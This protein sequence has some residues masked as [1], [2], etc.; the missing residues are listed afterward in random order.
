MHLLLDAVVELVRDDLV[1]MVLAP[2]HVHALAR[3]GVPRQELH[4]AQ[5][6][7][8]SEVWLDCEDLDML[9]RFQGNLY[10]WQHTSVVIRE[11]VITMLDQQI[12]PELAHA[13]IDNIELH[14]LLLAGCWAT[15]TVMRCLDAIP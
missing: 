2:N 6:M 11:H 15:K 13:V 10:Y 14:G 12:G 4:R 5:G 3:K 8:H 1:P 9:Y 7:G